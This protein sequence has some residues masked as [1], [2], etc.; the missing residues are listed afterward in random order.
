MRCKCLAQLVKDGRC[1]ETMMYFE[2]KWICC[3]QWAW[4]TKT[5]PASAGSWKQRRQVSNKGTLCFWDVL[6]YG[7]IRVG[8]FGPLQAP[9]RAYCF[10]PSRLRQLKPL[11]LIDSRH[12]N[13]VI[14]FEYPTK[15]MRKRLS[16]STFGCW[17][18]THKIY[19]ALACL[20][21]NKQNKLHLA[22]CDL[23]LTTKSCMILSS[24]KIRK[25]RP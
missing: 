1:V 17:N 5:A 3:M 14:S 22:N 16:P 11:P 15:V 6:S 13:S 18:E 4:S 20:Y 7:S 9:D 12:S 25:K 19:R 21:F 10:K 8:L 24:F 2:P 23:S